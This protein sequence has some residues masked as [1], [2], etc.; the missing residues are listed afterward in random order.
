M[1]DVVLGEQFQVAPGIWALR[2]PHTRDQIMWSEHEHRVSAQ[3][4]H[5]FDDHR[6]HN[7]PLDTGR[8]INTRDKELRGFV[9]NIQTITTALIQ[10]SWWG[11]WG[12]AEPDVLVD[13]ELELDGRAHLSDIYRL[14]PTWACEWFAEPQHYA[15]YLDG[16]PASP[17]RHQPIPSPSSYQPGDRYRFSGEDFTR[18]GRRPRD[19]QQDPNAHFDDLP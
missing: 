19:P 9:Q 11:A 18:P 5:I 8:W 4:G 3:R 6:S 7:L 10:P 14:G 1:V 16:Q 15:V 13:I 12:I 2:L 17:V